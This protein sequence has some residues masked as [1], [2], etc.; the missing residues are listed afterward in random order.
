M[1]TSATSGHHAA[2]RQRPVHEEAALQ[3]VL[4]RFRS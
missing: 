3:W 4:C 2:N 1:P